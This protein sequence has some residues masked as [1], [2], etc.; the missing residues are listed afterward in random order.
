MLREVPL[1]EVLAEAIAPAIAELGPQRPPAGATP[2]LADAASASSS[3][4]LPPLSP[5]AAASAPSDAADSATSPPSSK[6]AGSSSSGVSPGADQPTAA[7]ASLGAAAAAPPKL[8][9]KF[10]ET[11]GKA[12]P[13]LEV[14][15]TLGLA[16][17]EAHTLDTAALRKRLA[18]L[19]HVDVSAV[20]GVS[21]ADASG[22]KATLVSTAVVSADPTVVD[23]AALALGQCSAKVVSEALQV[24]RAP[25]ISRHLP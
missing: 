16:P 21:L 17:A 3:K 4:I 9:E 14:E 6:P 8:S 5:R 10:V 11:A 23:S 22:G 15:L 18:G 19:L 7:T 12:L 25:T 24:G 20:D 1:A 13:T 2:P